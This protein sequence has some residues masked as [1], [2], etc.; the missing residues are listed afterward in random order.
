MRARRRGAFGAGRLRGAS[1]RGL[2]AAERA[3]A[4]SGAA[5]RVLGLVA[6]TC[7]TRGSPPPARR[8]RARAHRRAAS[9][10]A[11]RAPRS[12]TACTRPSADAR[13]R[14]AASRTARAAHR[15]ARPS[16]TGTVRTRPRRTG[17]RVA[18]RVGA[19]LRGPRRV[20]V[21]HRRHVL[22]RLG[23]RGASAC[24][25]SPRGSAGGES[26]S[27]SATGGTFSRGSAARGASA[28]ARLHAAWP[29]AASRRPRRP[30][31][32]PLHAAQRPAARVRAASHRSADRRRTPRAGAPPR[33]R[34]G[35]ARRGAPSGARRRPGGPCPRRLQAAAGD[36]RGG[37]HVRPRRERGHLLCVVGPSACRTR[38]KPV[39]A[40][41]RR[42]DSRTGGQGQ[43]PSGHP[44]E[45]C[46]TALPRVAILGLQQRGAAGAPSSP[47]DER[48]L[49]DHRDHQAL[50]VH[51]GARRRRRSR[52]SPTPR[53]RSCSSWSL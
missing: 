23:G 21:R 49:A 27:A 51:V 39:A 10:A 19:R 16:V 25:T 43:R 35:G 26:A 22:T 6:Q 14:R 38:A 52:S 34:P 28:G 15:T 30:P 42:A 31:A 48:Q 40:L 3:A 13:S 33:R 29:A 17:V 8:P 44:S 50:A 11:P 47:V 12:G 36:P 5:R 1:A 32:A 24:G 45:R 46:P 2:R 41:A 4:A 20:G 53:A 7:S 37:Q 18:R 9:P